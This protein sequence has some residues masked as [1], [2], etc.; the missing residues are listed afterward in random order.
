MHMHVQVGDWRDVGR[1]MQQLRL[2]PS[3]LFYQAGD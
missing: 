2:Q 1:A 3:L